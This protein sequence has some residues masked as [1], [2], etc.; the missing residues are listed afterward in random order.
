MNFNSNI[1]EVSDPSDWDNCKLPSLS[2]LDS[3]LR[4]Q[5][6]KDF[7][8]APVLTNCGHV[9]CSICIRRTISNSN[10]CPLCL[11]ETYESSLRKVLIL[12]NIVKWFNNNRNDLLKNL[13]ID[14]VN[15]SQND[16]SSDISVIS[17]LNGNVNED[18][19]VNEGKKEKE[20]HDIL[21]NVQYVVFL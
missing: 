19:N 17:E 15:D 3:L 16:S 10:K 21:L 14:L 8:N 18:V 12:D 6:C 2:N 9:F 4:C 11:E 7:L 13:S 1:N 5:I 20:A